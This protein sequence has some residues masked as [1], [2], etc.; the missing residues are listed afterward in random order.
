[1]TDEYNF[2][3]TDSEN[4]NFEISDTETYNFELGCGLDNVLF[5]DSYSN[6]PTTGSQLAIYISQDTNYTYRWDGSAYIQI[7]GGSGG[8]TTYSDN[9]VSVNPDQAEVVGITYTNYNSARLYATSQSPSA[10]N[11]WTIQLPSGETSEDIDVYQYIK[12]MGVAGTVLTGALTSV[13]PFTGTEYFDALIQNCQ[14]HDLVVGAGKILTVYNSTISGCGDLSNGLLIT[15]YSTLESACDFSTMAFFQSLNTDFFDFVGDSFTFGNGNIIYGGTIIA[16]IIVNNGNANF[17]NTNFGGN[18]ITINSGATLNTSACLSIGTITNNGTHNN[19]GDF[20][21]NTTSGLIATEM[22]GAIDELSTISGGSSQVVYWEAESFSD[23]Y[24]IYD[25]ITNPTIVMVKEAKTIPAGTY[26]LGLIEF[27]GYSG[28]EIQVQ[29][30]T[31]VILTTIPHILRNISF[32]YNSTLKTGAGSNDIYLFDS[33]ISSV[34]AVSSAYLVDDDDNKA[35]LNIVAYNSTVGTNIMTMVNTGAYAALTMYDRSTLRADAFVTTGGAIKVSSDLSSINNLAYDSTYSAYLTTHI[36]GNDQSKAI[37]ENVVLDASQRLII[38][39]TD[40]A[41]VQLTLPNIRECGDGFITIVDTKGALETNNATIIPDPTD[42]STINN[43]SSYVMDKN[44]GSVVLYA[45]GTNWFIVS[46]IAG[47][48][49]VSPLTTKGDLLAYSTE[50]IR[51]GVG[52]NDQVLTADSTTASGIKWA[53][54][55]SGG[56]SDPMTTRGDIIYKSSSATTRLALGTNGQVLSSDGTDISWAD[57]SGS[58]DGTQTLTDG[59]TVSW[60]VDDGNCGILTLA[61]N[62]TL[63]NPT[64]LNAGSRYQL[65]VKQDSTGSRT[66]AY[67]TNFDFPGGVE[68]VLSSTASAVDILEFLAE[69]TIVLHLINFISDSQ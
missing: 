17:S 21:D 59:V 11:Q 12:V 48:D 28:N 22:Q 8:S 55:S 58:S 25:M 39:E 2:E 9:V 51:L 43:V 20:Y 61:G 38:V 68:P 63:S 3:I 33:N 49:Y 41:T 5:Y 24:N 65:I 1:M 23:L 40:T 7:G 67:G 37:N 18:D 50:D 42:S 62:R 10:T 52:T 16:D 64:N 35:T 34:E 36:I 54:P 47:S 56:F 19:Y 69:S 57:A 13:V 32:T 53:T 6:F 45:E 27:K 60:D 30:A 66:L 15:N 31:S 4:Y 46:K 14:I 44:F 29:C 26:S